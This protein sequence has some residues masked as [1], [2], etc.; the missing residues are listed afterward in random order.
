M[1]IRLTTLVIAF[2]LFFLTDA[3]GQTERRESMFRPVVGGGFL[4]GGSFSPNQ[5]NY[6][7]GGV[8]RLGLQTKFLEKHNAAILLGINQFDR[9]I[10]YPLMLQFRWVNNPDK[11]LG[12]LTSFGY[13]PGKGEFEIESDDYELE[14]GF[15]IELGAQWKFDLGNQ[16]AM[17][18][19]ISVSRQRA[20]LE[21]NPEFS[22]SY[23]VEDD[24]IAVV[25]AINLQLGR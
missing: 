6:L 25:F 15:Y 11:A 12:F 2:L 1:K 4:S 14:G 9:D 8:A 7:S 13:S 17:M 21:Y 24:R 3:F 22:S 19:S 18:P 5:F 23:E 10:F 20:I 16:W